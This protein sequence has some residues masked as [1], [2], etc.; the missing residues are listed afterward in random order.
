MSLDFDI[1]FEEEII[2]QALKDTDYL[3]KASRLLDA[4]HFNSPQ[5]AWVWKTLG[6]TW[7][8]YRERATVRLIISEAKRQY[9]D[10]DDR[11]PYLE[12]VRKLYKKKIVAPVATLDRLVEFVKIVNAQLALEQAATALEKGKTKLVYE[13]LNKVVRQ[14]IEPKIY[15][16]IQWIEEF[17]KRQA[18][19]KR[20]KE[21]PEENII[22][23]TGFKRLD[24][25]IDGIQL[26]ELG[27]M[28]A[29]TGQGKSIMLT[30]LAYYALKMGFSVVY[31]ALEMPARQIA[32]RQDARWLGITYNK[33][34]N[35]DFT[36][37]ELKEIDSRLEEVHELWKNK[38]QIVSMP[39]RRCNINTIQ[40]ALEDLKDEFNFVPQLVL[41][42]SGDHLKGTGKFESH[43]LQQAEVYWDMKNLAEEEGYAVWSS[44]QA[45]KEWV[46]KLATAEASSE[47]YDK[48]RIADIICSLNTPGKESRST[49]I[50]VDK[51][52]DMDD[53]EEIVGKYME[54]FLAKYR[55][56]ESKVIIPVSP[57]FARMYISEI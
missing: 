28:L 40:G 30:N 22:I 37:S 20:K 1:H 3:K 46:Q 35:Y 11:L 43:R 23:P 27:M 13:V 51:E 25:I 39:V 42:D 44:A 16:T 7:K 19:R 34:K 50:V 15:T 33:F 31:F 4:H 17:E 49:R 8:Q 57:D 14:D 5:L 52:D 29:T 38:F 48:S 53:D 56:G 12:L 45:G 24:S 32:M 18:E 47:S 54:L 10:D 9:P 41:I 2:A 6:D 55:D 36:S 21:H 26:G